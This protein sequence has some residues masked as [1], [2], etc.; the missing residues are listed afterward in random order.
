[1]LI[2]L[3]QGLFAAFCTHQPI[4]RR[5]QELLLLK[6]TGLQPASA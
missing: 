1:M 5:V 6:W 3:K 4:E 2:L